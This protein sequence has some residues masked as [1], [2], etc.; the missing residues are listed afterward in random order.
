MAYEGL[1]MVGSYFKFSPVLYGL[2]AY[3]KEVQSLCP[4]FRSYHL[5]LVISAKVHQINELEVGLICSAITD[6]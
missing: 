3:I 6:D 2:D 5:I 4:L 1:S